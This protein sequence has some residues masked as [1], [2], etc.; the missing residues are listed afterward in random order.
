VRRTDRLRAQIALVFPD[1]AGARDAA[2]M[3]QKLLA[4]PP[5]FLTQWRDALRV[6]ASNDEARVTFELEAARAT[7]LDEAVIALLPAPTAPPPPK[8][9]PNVPPPQP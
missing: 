5:P 9:S 4:D 6:E 7:Q 1:P 8:P 2:A 3:L